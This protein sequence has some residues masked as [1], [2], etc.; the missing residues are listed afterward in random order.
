VLK[1]TIKK[2]ARYAGPVF[3]PYILISP[4]KAHA[5]D[6]LTQLATKTFVNGPGSVVV[7]IVLICLVSWIGQYLIKAIGKGQ[8]AELINVATTLTSLLLV[9]GVAGKV[10]IELAKFAGLK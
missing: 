7:M 6:A 4:G 8:W 5:A 3:V 9:I 2:L 1:L 10:L